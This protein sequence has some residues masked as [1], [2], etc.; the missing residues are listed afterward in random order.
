V[1]GEL[2]AIDGS[3]YKISCHD[4]IPLHFQDLQDGEGGG[5]QRGDVGGGQRGEE[6]DR[7]TETET[8][9]QRQTDRDRQR[10]KTHFA[11]LEQRV[12]VV[13]VCPQDGRNVIRIHAPNGLCWRVT[14]PR[15]SEL[16]D[17][18]NRFVRYISV[19][20]AHRLALETASDGTLSGAHLH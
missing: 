9:R 17:V 13:R 19:N 16:R 8:D 14:S 20:S 11:Q 7:E 10:E 18:S 2:E 3:L 4:N 1:E 6:R 15:R 12:D 5:Y